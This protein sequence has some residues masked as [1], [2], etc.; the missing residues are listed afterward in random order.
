MRELSSNDELTSAFPLMRQLRPELKLGEYL[1]KI[2]TAKAHSGY[3]L[4]AFDYDGV[5]AGL[6]GVLPF[7]VLYHNDC[8]FVAD[9]VVDDALRGKG[10]GQKFFKR[11]ESWAKNEGFKEIELSSRFFRVDAHRFYVEKLG[12]E[13]T[14]FVFQKAL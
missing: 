3:R 14:S 11:V 2:A 1:D 8:L 6:C 10:L 13:K 5:V 4:F 9:F 12:F 7:F